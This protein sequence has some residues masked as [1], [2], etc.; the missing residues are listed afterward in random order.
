MTFSRLCILIGLLLIL[1]TVYALSA[2]QTTFITAFL[3]AV[4]G[5]LLIA[6]GIL[7]ERNPSMRNQVVVATLI[8]AGL[9][10][11]GSLRILF[12]FNDPTQNPASVLA[13][14][15]TLILSAIVSITG[16]RLF[17]TTRRSK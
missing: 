16:I 3:P 9:T 8:I 6:L 13:H 7:G 17:L 4:S 1:V 15:A 10:L 12:I 5:G 2:A 14:L 11:V